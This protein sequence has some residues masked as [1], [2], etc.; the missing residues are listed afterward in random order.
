MSYSKEL[1]YHLILYSISQDE[2]ENEEGEEDISVAIDTESL[3]DQEI[4]NLAN[5]SNTLNSSF[6]TISGK[7]RKHPF[8]QVNIL[9]TS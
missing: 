9:S 1:L 2:N 5:I 7:G 8:F 6:Q 4:S 3:D